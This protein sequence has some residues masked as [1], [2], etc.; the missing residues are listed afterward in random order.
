M[1]D[2]DKDGSFGN[3]KKLLSCYSWIE[4]ILPIYIF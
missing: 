4:Y 1:E 3:P 2:N